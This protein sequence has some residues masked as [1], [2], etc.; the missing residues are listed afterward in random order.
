MNSKEHQSTRPQG[1]WFTLPGPKEPCKQNHPA[2]S[3]AADDPQAGGG[4]PAGAPSARRDAELAA[5]LR[6]IAAS[7]E[8]G[9]KRC[10]MVGLAGYFIDGFPYAA[11][12]LTVDQS[13]TCEMRIHD[14]GFSCVAFFEPKLL[15][16]ETV[17]K[18]G[19][20]M[21]RFGAALVPAV[22]V[23]LEVKANDIFLVTEF[24]QGQQHNLF[25]DQDSVARLSG[26]W[27][28]AEEWYA[29]RERDQ[30]A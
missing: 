9:Q 4:K 30:G 5:A 24:I 20:V 6:E 10:F 8:Q 22:R 15:C 23:R 16:P 13:A 1:F 2:D 14:E 18:N 7:L 29:R 28:E 3:Q 12:G 21:K 17:E 11:S 19:F 25:F 26:F 27:Q